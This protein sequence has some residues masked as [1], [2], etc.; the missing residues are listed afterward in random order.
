MKTWTAPGRGPTRSLA[1]RPKNARESPFLPWSHF[2]KGSFPGCSRAVFDRFFAVPHGTRGD[3]NR[4]PSIPPPP[5]GGPRVTFNSNLKVTR[6]PARKIP[7]FKPVICPAGAWQGPCRDP[8]GTQGRTQGTRPGPLW[9]PG[10]GRDLCQDLCIIS[11][12]I[13]SY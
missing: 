10:A 7:R 3:P 5:P 4:V 6:A 12:G 9:D 1:G 11:R 2:T 13:L 8:P